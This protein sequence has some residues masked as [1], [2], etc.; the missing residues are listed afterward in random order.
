MEEVKEIEVKE[1]KPKRKTTAKH[2]LSK[3][4]NK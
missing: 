1:T 4:K 3:C 2:Y